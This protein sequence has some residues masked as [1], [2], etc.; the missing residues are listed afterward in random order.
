MDL[1][2]SLPVLLVKGIGELDFPKALKRDLFTTT[3]SCQSVYLNSSET[4]RNES[5]FIVC[6]ASTYIHQNSVVKDNVLAN[7]MNILTPNLVNF[8]HKP[9]LVNNP[10]DRLRIEIVDYHFERQ[11]VS[12]LAVFEL[13]GKVSNK[14]LAV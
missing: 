6:K 4:A 9:V 7:F 1:N 3:I 13:T 2:I 8:Y 10:Q 11:K 5:L 14:L 12:A